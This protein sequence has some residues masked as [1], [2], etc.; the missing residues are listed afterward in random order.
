MKAGK[1]KSKIP[2]STQGISRSVSGDMIYLERDPDAQLLQRRQRTLS[3]D[4]GINAAPRAYKTYEEELADY[5]GRTGSVDRLAQRGRPR[6]IRMGT[7][8][9]HSQ[10]VRSVPVSLERRHSE[11]GSRSTSSDSR[12]V[13]RVY[14]D[15]YLPVTDTRSLKRSS[16]PAAPI[17]RSG[18]AQS[19]TMP[20]MSKR[21]VATG[22]TTVYLAS[23]TSQIPRAPVYNDRH[24]CA[25][26]KTGYGGG[27]GE[28]YLHTATKT[29]KSGASNSSLS[30]CDRSTGSA[31]AYSDRSKQYD[32]PKRLKTE[33][34]DAGNISLVHLFNPIVRHTLL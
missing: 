26:T 3:I 18:S 25:A 34:C 24:L 2:I 4:R 12:N 14:I 22:A 15:G 9:A 23:K 21:P 16:D 19:S 17:Q 28:R 7:Q 11:A 27:Y 1:C 6:T 30:Y 33:A 10:G 13:N 31:P 8:S 29:V 20:R 5:H 32:A